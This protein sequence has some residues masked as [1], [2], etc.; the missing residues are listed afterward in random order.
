MRIKPLVATLCLCSLSLADYTIQIDISDKLNISKS[1]IVTP[2]T[3]DEW[4]TTTPLYSNYVEKRS[5]YNC[6]NWLPDAST[7]TTGTTFQQDAS[8]CKVDQERS[9]QAQEKNT[10]TN[11]VRS[12]GSPTTEINTLSNQTGHRSYT[13]ALSEWISSDSTCGNWLP[14]P[15]SL[16]ATPTNITQQTQTCNENKTRTRSESYVDN[17]SSQ[18]VSLPDKTETN[19]EPTTKSRSTNESFNCKS[20]TVGDDWNVYMVFK[21]GSGQYALVEDNDFT[22]QNTG[23]YQFS[24]GVEYKESP[25]DTNVSIFYRGNFVETRNY[26]EKVV[27]IYQVCTRKFEWDEE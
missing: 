18:L 9:V 27:D 2:P 14:Q 21:D 6:S 1:P 8:N 22:N 19:A 11:A 23:N 20:D 4:I 24:T 5:A 7:I 3:E 15:L 10:R 25:S 17:E 13:V 26:F 12:V 16:P